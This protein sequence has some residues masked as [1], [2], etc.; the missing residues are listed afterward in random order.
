M[1]VGLNNKEAIT[2]Y[3]AGEITT[4][5]LDMILGQNLAL[6]LEGTGLELHFSDRKNPLYE[7][8]NKKREQIAY[9]WIR[10]KKGVFFQKVI[11]PLIIKTINLIHEQMIKRYDEQIFVCD[12]P[13]LV[14]MNTFLANYIETEFTHCRPYKTDF[15]HKIRDIIFGLAK[16]DK[17]Y[18]NR[19]LDFADK[20]V[21]EFPDGFELTESEKNNIETYH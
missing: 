16:E 10:H 14:R 4:D 9:S 13:R 21:K 15:M 6:S 1:E 19:L 12:D 7:G 5:Q 8:N 17:Y 11:K 18:G 20:F 3:D 2:L